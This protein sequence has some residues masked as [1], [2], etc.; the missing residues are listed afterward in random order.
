MKGHVTERRRMTTVM[1][2]V[3]HS[4]HALCIMLKLVL[5]IETSLPDDGDDDDGGQL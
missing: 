1:T 4:V 3:T 2:S 5:T